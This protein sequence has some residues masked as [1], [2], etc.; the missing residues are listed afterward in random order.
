MADD[1]IADSSPAPRSPSDLLA[2]A[3]PEALTAWR[4]TGTLP[5]ETPSP[6]ADSTSASAPAEQAVDTGTPDAP[7]AAPS[8]ARKPRVDNAETRKVALAAE[9]QALLQQRALLRREFDTP[10]TTP[11]PR[12]DVRPAASSPAPA[13]DPEPD[14][15]DA[16]TYPDGIY[17]RKFMKDQA[18]WEARTVLRQ[19]REAAITRHRQAQAD[20]AAYERGQAWVERVDA[21]RAKYPDW[22]QKIATVAILEGSPIDVWV[23]ESP[24]G[25]ELLYGPLSNPAEVRRI[26]ALSPLQQVRE[27][28]LLE[29]GLEPAP[30]KTITDAPDPPRT[31]GDRS[32]APVDAARRALVNKDFGSYNEAQNARELAAWRASHRR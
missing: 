28:V 15:E 13:T 10:Q 12:A 22:E 5:T 24:Q 7:P 20:H 31:L 3:S 14:P 26:A 9:I 6:D 30:A 32:A 25:A 4:Q 23:M 18:N 21:A 11:P 17:D 27:L 8:P 16:A 19:E 1:P 29:K 2:S